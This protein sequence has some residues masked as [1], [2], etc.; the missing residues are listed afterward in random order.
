MFNSLKEPFQIDKYIFNPA[1][2]SDTFVL[3]VF[4]LPFFYFSVKHLKRRGFMLLFILKFMAILLFLISDILL[5]YG[6]LKFAS[7]GDARNAK[8]ARKQL[9][10]GFFLNI[11]AMVIFVVSYAYQGIVFQDYAIWDWIF[12]YS[13]LGCF[14][15]F[16]CSAFL[17]K[18]NDKLLHK[19]IQDTLFRKIDSIFLNIAVLSFIACAICFQLF[20]IVVNF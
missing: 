19:K 5:A 1:K 20:A 14:V 6:F 18:L 4:S 12:A 11:I 10:F 13:S 7:S 2:T 9:I 8:H 16:L 17:C 15:V 3:L